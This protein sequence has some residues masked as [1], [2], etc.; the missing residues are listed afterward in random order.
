MLRILMLITL[1]RTRRHSV[2]PVFE[3]FFSSYSA[4]RNSRGFPIFQGGQTEWR[5]V[6]RIRVPARAG[7]RSC[8]DVARNV[9]TG[10]KKIKQI[11]NFTLEIPPPTVGGAG[12][13]SV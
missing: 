1:K 13:P 4:V 2:W 9:S 5:W 11:I 8:R 7:N 3:C 12:I 10:D 6:F